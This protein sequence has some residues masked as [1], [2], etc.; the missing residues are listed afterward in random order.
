MV[1]EENVRKAESIIGHTFVVK[2]YI[3]DALT[4]AGAEE[5]NYEGNRKLSQVGDSLIDA[6]L[7]SIIYG[8]NATR[9]EIPPNLFV[10]E[11][12]SGH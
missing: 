10:Q 7:A 12:S 3:H 4:A 6:I 9:G 5:E 11:N 8:T 1:P 2:R